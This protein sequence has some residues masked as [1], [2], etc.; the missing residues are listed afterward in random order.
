LDRADALVLLAPA[1]AALHPLPLDPGGRAVVPAVLAPIAGERLAGQRVFAFAGIGRPGKFFATLRWL[2]AEVVGERS[3]PD[4]HRFRA[5]ELAALRRAARRA[6]AR[7]VT[8]AKD[9]VRL[10]PTVRAEVDILEVEIRWPD[11]GVLT[12]LLGSL[13][14]QAAID[15][16]GPP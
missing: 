1:G 15:E 9:G 12:S 7:L 8:T 13:L 11:P 10:A 6:G 16:P 3:F 2:G 14:P 5:R 4:H